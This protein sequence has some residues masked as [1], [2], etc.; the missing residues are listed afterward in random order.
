MHHIPPLTD[1]ILQ[2]VSPP[3]ITGDLDFGEYLVQGVDLHMAQ[4]MPLPLTIVSVHLQ[5]CVLHGHCL[6]HI[7]RGCDCETIGSDQCP[8]HDMHVSCMHVTAV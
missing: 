8:A 7:L 5:S 6:S 1:D 2:S 4:L 3:T